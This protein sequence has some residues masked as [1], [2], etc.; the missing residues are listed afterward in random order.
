LVELCFQAAALWSLKTRGE[1]AFPAGLK[2]LRVYR[3]E[4]A[5]D[6]A[7]LWCRMRRTGED[8]FDGEVVD[9][10]GARYVALTGFRT[11]ARPA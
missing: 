3:Q 9:Q 7:R 6:G 10:T 11:V 5:E 4:P 2:T 1:M 8:T